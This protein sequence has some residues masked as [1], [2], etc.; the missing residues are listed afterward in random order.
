MTVQCP[1]PPE[2]LKWLKKLLPLGLALAFCL[3]GMTAMPDFEVMLNHI[4]G[5]GAGSFLLAGIPHSAVNSRLPFIDIIVSLIMNTG[6][7]P[8]A[9][10]L[11]LHL[12]LYLLVF[13]AGCIPGGYRAGLFAMAIAGFSAGQTLNGDIEQLF[14]SIFLLITLCLLL[15][16]S[17]EKTPAAGLLT[18]L[19]A[20]MTLTVRTPL[21]AFPLLL[22][23]SDGLAGGGRAAAKRAA[24]FLASC[25]LLLL[26]WA[27]LNRNAS[28][29]L[30]FFETSRAASNVI[31]AAMGSVYTGEANTR[32]AAGLEPGDSAE[33]YFFREVAKAP[34]FYAVTTAR[35]AWHIFLFHPVL[36]TLALAAALWGRKRAGPVPFL[37]PA[38]LAGIYAFFSIEAR[39][40]LP[41]VYLLP[42]LIAG[43]L[44]PPPVND[45]RSFLLAKRAAGAVFAAALGAVLLFFEV[46]L[47]AYPWRAARSP[48]TSGTFRRA[49]RLFPRDKTFR[50]RACREIWRDG[51]DRGFYDCL[52]GFD[53]SF[54]DPVKRYFLELRA[55]ARPA[56]VG[57]PDYGGNRKKLAELETLRL[58][59][60]T[61][62]GH[63]AEA[64]AAFLRA[65][66]A[67]MRTNSM[68][69]G[70][71]YE[72]DKEIALKLSRDTGG[73]YDVF[74]HDLLLFWPPAEIERL[75]TGLE[76]SG[77]LKGRLEYLREELA[78]ARGLGPGR[79]SLAR[80]WLTAELFGQW[81]DL[82][83]RGLMEAANRRQRGPGAD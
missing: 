38:Y 39:Y 73:Y 19:A 4:A 28:G 10:F 67:Y 17:R 65:M 5:S 78:Y 77:R 57:L 31:T 74:V 18:G 76:R 34:L 50:E 53:A 62:L 9:V 64:D 60:E 32:L 25:Y 2:Y 54:G 36:I 52:A 41:L 14:Y 23:L 66:D 71:P 47:A 22:L 27:L 21:F 24:I 6:V 48:V 81:K 56:E 59:R 3:R 69:R 45:G 43:F 46:P 61:Q 63:K 11:L 8:A 15:V 40:F 42:P 12:A 29:R 49:A 80:G 83:Q 7:S 37:L 51:D 72:R 33:S 79:D 58:L 20:G 26:P 16:K 68:L 75:L 13:I 30:E 35:R 1:L 55:S 44:L 82:P 70:Q